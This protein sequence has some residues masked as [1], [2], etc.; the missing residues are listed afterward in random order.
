MK[1]NFCGIPMEEKTL[2]R[3]AASMMV[4]VFVLVAVMIVG[5]NHPNVAKA[6]AI[7]A[8]GLGVVVNFVF[9]FLEWRTGRM[10][11][12]INKISLPGERAT[13]WA[14]RKPD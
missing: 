13:Y 10:N 6:L 4:G 9:L 11:Y 14:Q 5:L 2:K 7:A 8:I 12:H 1:I 3:F